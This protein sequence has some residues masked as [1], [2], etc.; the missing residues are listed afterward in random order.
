MKT[1]IVYETLHGSS[2]KCSKILKE[3]LTHSADL[4]RLKENENIA[5][6][7]YDIIIIGGSIHM[8]VIHTRVKNFVEMNFRKILNKPHGLFICCMEQGENAMTQFDNAFPQKLRESA[9]ANGIFGG[10]LILKKMNLFEKNLIKKIT[11]L[12]HPLSNINLEEINKFAEKI[13]KTGV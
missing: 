11:R 7:E 4:H 8:G 10:E 6:D 1:L 9:L 12:K 13:N 2:E 3:K 5:I